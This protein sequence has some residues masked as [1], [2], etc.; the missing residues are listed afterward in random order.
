M[1]RICS[2][3]FGARLDSGTAPLLGADVHDPNSH[4]S[5]LP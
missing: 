2:V 1:A 3:V 4:P 5:I